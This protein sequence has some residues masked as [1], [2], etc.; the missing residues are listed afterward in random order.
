MGH[1]ALCLLCHAACGTRA[2][3]HGLNQHP[4]QHNTAL[5]RM[6]PWAQ[7]FLYS[8]RDHHV[9]GRQLLSG[10]S[11]LAGE[12]LAPYEARTDNLEPHVLL[13]SNG[14]GRTIRMLSCSCAPGS[15]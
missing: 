10:K 14:D 8:G 1:T 13:C 2:R 9:R 15:S 7:L 11:V 6:L 12:Q 5:E 4:H 3:R